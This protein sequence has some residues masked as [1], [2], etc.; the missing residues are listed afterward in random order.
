LTGS[1]FDLGLVGLVQFL[2]AVLL[3]LL[4]G[5]VADRHDRRRIA[6]L[7]QSVEA[8]VV[9]LLAAGSVMGWITE[10]AILALVFVIGGVRAFETPSLRQCYRRWFRRACCPRQW[11]RALQRC[12]RPSSLVRPSGGS[13]TSPGRRGP[14]APAQRCSSQLRC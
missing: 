14:T 1:A 7:C 13:C 9:L 11:H 6:S 4:A 2:P 12:R 5:H 10:Y 3:L 8:L